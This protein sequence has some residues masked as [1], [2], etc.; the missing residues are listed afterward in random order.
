MPAI[1]QAVY[2]VLAADA[3][4]GSLL[5]LYRGFPAIFTADPVPADAPLPLIVSS[6]L[7]AGPTQ[8]PEASKQTIAARPVQ[9]IRCIDEAKGSM[10]L[11]T[12]IAM[13][14]FWLFER[15]EFEIQGWHLVRSRASMPFLGESDGRFYT[16]IVTVTLAIEGGSE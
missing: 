16:L 4:L 1:T 12:T 10:A 8:V 14:V 5:G 9:D 2:D 3:Q 6:G 13:R 7:V 15:A 11:I